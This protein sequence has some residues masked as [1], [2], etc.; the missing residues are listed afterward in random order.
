MSAEYFDPTGGL[1]QRPEFGQIGVAG[2]RKNCCAPPGVMLPGVQPQCEGAQ[3]WL[4]H[5]IRGFGSTG[6]GCEL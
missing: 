2:K 5:R 1:M 3:Q 4:H 6:H